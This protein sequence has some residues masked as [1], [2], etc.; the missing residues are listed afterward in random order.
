MNIKVLDYNFK[1][2]KIK[3]EPF[4]EKNTE[5]SSV[6]LAG[7]ETSTIPSH[8]F[9][10]AYGVVPF[11][12]SIDVSKPN[13]Y[14]LPFKANPLYNIN[15]RKLMPNGEYELTPAL[16][17]QLIKRSKTDKKCILNLKKIWEDTTEYGGGIFKD[18]LED[19]SSK[20]SYFCTELIDPK[21]G[22]DKRIT[23]IVKTTN[24]KNP[25]NKDSFFVKFMQSSPEIANIKDPP[26]KG[27]GEL[28]LCELVKI[29]KENGFKEIKL[30]STMDSFYEKM[31]FEKYENIV[32]PYR[33]D[34]LKFDS[35]IERIKKYGNIVTRYR[36]DSSQFDSFIERVEKKYELI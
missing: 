31:G 32:P 5:K 30:S 35:F 33:L 9:R 26:I 18:F 2:D 34:F 1:N 15:L 17:C 4:K 20:A 23:C 12:A 29:A 6:N 7:V 19:K 21:I 10:G 13:S 8:L 3:N 28:C 11:K 16:F 25:E 36:L 22:L 27:S 14:N 24:P